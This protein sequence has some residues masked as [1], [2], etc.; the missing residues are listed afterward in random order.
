M[1]LNQLTASKIKDIRRNLGFTTEAMAKDLGISK[2]AYSQMENGKVEITLSRIEMI[3]GICNIPVT[4]IIPVTSP[5]QQ[6][7]NGSGNYNSAATHNGDNNF[8]ADAEDKLQS[9]VDNLNAALASVKTAKNKE[10]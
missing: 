8:F 6:V 2:T 3:A 10:Q 7:I 4:E 9:I 5:N 1:N